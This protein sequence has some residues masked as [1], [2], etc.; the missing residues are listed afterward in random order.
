MTRTRNTLY[1]WPLVTSLATLA[2]CAD[3]SG[4][5]E[6]GAA[7]CEAITGCD[8]NRVC[9]ITAPNTTG[10]CEI[11]DGR[12][13]SAEAAAR[14]CYPDARCQFRSDASDGGAVSGQCTFAPPSRQGFSVPAQIT[15]QRPANDALAPAIQDVSFQWEPPTAERG[16]QTTTVAVV[17]DTVPV[18]TPTRQ[19][20]NRTHIKWIWSSAD[21]GGPV[22]DGTVPFHFGRRGVAA[23]G[24]LGAQWGADS[25]APGTYVWFVF[26]IVQG[27]VVAS[28]AVQK[29]AVGVATAPPAFCL[30]NSD[31]VQGAELP[32]MV[33]CVRSRCRRR[34]ASDLDCSA[35]GGTCDFTVITGSRTRHGAFC[36]LPTGAPF[37]G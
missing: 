25:L 31:C 36:A 24:S 33:E 34:C 23:D 37:G 26:A 35:Y 20:A 17:M 6:A 18:I 14:E 21:P 1:S 11:P 19:I 12:C 29:F 3:V 30:R 2:S 32:E 9:V 27:Q 13:T 15:L 28:S 22:Q 10:R 5:F 4:S 16:V 7:P 8:S